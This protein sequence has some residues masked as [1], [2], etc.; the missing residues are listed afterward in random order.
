MSKN[1]IVEVAPRMAQGEY[2]ACLQGDQGIWGQGKSIEAAVLSFIGTH[3]NE[4]GIS[5]EELNSIHKCP[6]CRKEGFCPINY[7]KILDKTVNRL[8][9]LGTE[10]EV[11]FL[12]TEIR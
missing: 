5:T 4:L 2:H 11:I 3:H 7:R 12:P 8:K 10:I 6:S 9:E 1:V